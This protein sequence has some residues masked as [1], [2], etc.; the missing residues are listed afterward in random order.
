MKSSQFRDEGWRKKERKRERH[1]QEISNVERA[2]IWRKRN[3]TRTICI[4]LCVCVFGRKIFINKR[5]K[6]KRRVVWFQSDDDRMI[7]E[8]RTIWFRH[9]ARHWDR[10]IERVRE[11]K[12]WNRPT[13]THTHTCTRTLWNVSW[14]GEE[15]EEERSVLRNTTG[16]CHNIQEEEE[17]EKQKARRRSTFSHRHCA[18]NGDTFENWW[19]EDRNLDASTCRSVVGLHRRYVEKVRPCFY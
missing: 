9:F 19:I 18:S 15:E 17:R 4:H 8:E 14:R 3:L 1:T 7:G 11:R 10:S 6:R 2:R 12:V 5:R 13:Y 16:F